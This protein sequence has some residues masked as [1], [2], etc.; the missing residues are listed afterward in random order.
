MDRGVRKT[1]EAPNNPRVIL[2]CNARKSIGI[3]KAFESGFAL[4][5]VME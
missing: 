4:S 1:I 3:K 2:S 5:K